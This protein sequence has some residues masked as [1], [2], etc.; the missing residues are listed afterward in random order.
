LK[1]SRSK[2]HVFFDRGHIKFSDY[3]LCERPV[4]RILLTQ[5]YFFKQIAASLPSRVVFLPSLITVII[6]SILSS[7]LL[8]N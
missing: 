8:Q 2:L 5:F 7:P 6:C 4:L 3:V 1:L